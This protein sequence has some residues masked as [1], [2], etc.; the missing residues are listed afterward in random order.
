MNSRLDV[1]LWSR[2]A[3]VHFSSVFAKMVRKVEEI[4]LIYSKFD[5]R[6][7]L[8][9]LNKNAG[10]TSVEVSASL[11]SM[12]K[13]SV[14]YHLKTKGYFNIGYTSAQSLDSQ[15]IFDDDGQRVA[16]TS[17][18]VEL[19]F[20]GVGKGIALKEL[21]AIIAQEEKMNAFICFGGSSVLT[22]GHHPYGDYWPLALEDDV[23]TTLDLRN[24]A[25]SISGLHRHNVSEPMHVVEPQTGELKHRQLLVAVK[26]DCPVEAEILSTALLV[27]PQEYHRS[28]LNNFNV[29]KLILQS[30]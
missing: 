27:A 30:L 4:E 20:G 14:E 29:N 16:F 25:L 9:H 8:Y 11:W 24:D 21:A 18:R 28:I 5:E 23:Q 3:N 7:E 17:E 22:R 15:L 19:D 6:A 12:L 13:K 1:V 26:M 10:K 2:N